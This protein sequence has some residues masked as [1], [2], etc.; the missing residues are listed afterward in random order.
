M[1]TEALMDLSRY[2][3]DQVMFGVDVI[4]QVNP[5][6]GDMRHLDG[7]VFAGINDDYGPHAIGFKDTHKDEFWVPGHIPGRPLLPGVLMIETAAQLASFLVKKFHEE[8]GFLGFIGCDNVKFR[9]QVTPGQRLYI[10][11]RETYYRAGRR[12]TCVAQ[13]MVEG[14]IVFEGTIKGMSFEVRSDGGS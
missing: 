13:G 8:P 3:L 10:F 14:K 12:F 4:E 6:R 5:Q 7:V 11:G 2:N 1:P 9:G